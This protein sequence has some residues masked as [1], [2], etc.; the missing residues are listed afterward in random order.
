MLFFSHAIFN[1]KAQSRRS[2]RCSWITVRYSNIIPYKADNFLRCVEDRYDNRPSRDH[3]IFEVACV[4]FTASS[5]MDRVPA[6][7][8]AGAAAA[9]VASSNSARGELCWA[10]AGKTTY[11]WFA[12]EFT[13]RGR[14]GHNL[15]GKPPE[16][17]VGVSLVTFG[18]RQL[19]EG[20]P[21]TPGGIPSNR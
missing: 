13:A 4:W 15:A 1:R 9:A 8:V 5:R 10:R 3:E 18:Q 2:S 6:A 7:A 12:C 17:S 21:N 19:T 16:R 11:E 14:N 20:P